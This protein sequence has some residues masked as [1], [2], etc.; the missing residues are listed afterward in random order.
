MVRYTQLESIMSE[1]SDNHLDKMAMVEA[2]QIPSERYNLFLDKVEMI[3]TNHSPINGKVARL[4]FEFME[5]TGLRITETLNVKKQD[6]DFDTRILTVT[7]PKS[8]K[9]CK[10]STWKYK[11]LQTRQRTLASV[12]KDCKV[13]GGKGK[14]K[15]PQRTTFTPRIRDILLE[16]CDTL[17]PTDHLFTAS[18]V[19]FWK[20][21]KKAGVKAGIHIFQQ[22]EERMIKGMYLHLFRAFCSKRTLKDARD[23]DFKDQL[24]AAKLR[25]TFATVTDRYTKIDINYLINWENSVY[26]K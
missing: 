4:G 15:K 22:K 20:W 13:C 19:S 7:H 18:R 9:Q 21:S 12:D 17:E 1:D 2:N 24:V 11:D 16:Y 10:C 14:W 5:D 8:E 23:D 6:I 25:H 3:P 26:E